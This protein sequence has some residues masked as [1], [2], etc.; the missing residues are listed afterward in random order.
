MARSKEKILHP[1]LSYLVTGLCYKIHNDLGRYRSEK[2]YADALEALLKKESINYSR[3]AA[4]PPSFIGEGKRR[5]I[6]DFL[7]E[8]KIIVDLKTKRFISKE[9]YYQIKRYLSSYNKE[10]G[11]IINFREYRLKPKRILNKIHS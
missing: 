9:D 3:E 1:E 8:D 10:L 2:Q 11:I 4:L 6:P 7:V 5:N